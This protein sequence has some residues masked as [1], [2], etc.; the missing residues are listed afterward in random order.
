MVSLVTG[1]QKLEDYN[2]RA[3]GSSFSLLENAN[4]LREKVSPV[5]NSS[6]SGSFYTNTNDMLSGTQRKRS[7][8]LDV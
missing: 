2:V 7:P 6:R 3:G 1:K 4:L 5:E 8:S